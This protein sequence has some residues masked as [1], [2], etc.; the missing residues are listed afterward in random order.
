VGDET[1]SGDEVV[2]PRDRVKALGF[3]GGGIAVVI[4]L[5][6]WLF[7]AVI[8][9]GCTTPSAMVVTN[10]S[11]VDATLEWQTDG[12]LGT[13][14]FGSAGTSRVAACE[15]FTPILQPG[16][17]HRVTIRTTQASRAFAFVAPESGDSWPGV[18]VVI[19]PDGSIDRSWGGDAGDQPP[20]GT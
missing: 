16:A 19:R 8:T 12:L 2:T 3:V 4:G 6:I 7:S 20:C 1:L 15:V 14:I 13:P 10:R 18:F 17:T 5:T 11:A 9:C